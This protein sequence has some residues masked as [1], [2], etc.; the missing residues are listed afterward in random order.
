MFIL[1]FVIFFVGVT[2][3]SLS[4]ILIRIRFFNSNVFMAFRDQHK[5]ANQVPRVGVAFMD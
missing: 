5:L 2:F 3:G 4:D 1:G